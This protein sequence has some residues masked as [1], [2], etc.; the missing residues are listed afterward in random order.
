MTVPVEERKASQAEQ[1]VPQVPFDGTG[2]GGPQTP[3]SALFEK[4]NTSRAGLTSQEAQGRL[5]KIG[6]NEPAPQRQ[7]T[8]LV[9]ILLLF[10]NPLVGILLFASLVSAIVGDQVNAAIILVIVLLSVALNFYQSYRSQ[11]AAERLRAQVSPTA[12]ALRDGQW[13]EIPRRE[14]VPGDII[15]LSAGDMVPADARL[16]EERDLHVQQAALTGESMP[17]EKEA[18]DVDPDAKSP[19]EARNAVFLGTSVV[20]G[21]ATALV[22]ST[23]PNT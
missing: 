8:I 11:Q 16:I 22:V 21:L 3:L 18:I 12:T 19:V 23:G 10:A 1:P 7:A 2:K 17:V 5:G 6:P 4:L 13:V 9:Q 20:S 14:L 15:R